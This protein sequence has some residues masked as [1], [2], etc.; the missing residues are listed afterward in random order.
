MRVAASVL[1]LLFAFSAAAAKLA[2]C[3][4]EPSVAGVAAP[5]HNDSREVYLGDAVDIWVCHLAPFLNDVSKQD[6]KVTLYIDG[7]DSGVTPTGVDR[8]TGRIRF[9]LER[10]DDN[11]ELWRD[12]L[13]NP[14][15]NRL[16]TI[17]IGVG[18][19]GERQLTRAEGANTQVT[20]NK[21]WLHWSTSL[22]LIGLALMIGVFLLYARNSDMLRSGPK[23]GGIRQAYSLARTQMAWWF[24]LVVIGYVFIWLVAGDRDSIPASLLGLMGISAATAL[25]ARAVAVPG[26][27]RAAALRKE[28]DLQRT[29]LEE[30]IARI[31]T[32]LA[33]TTDATLQATL[34][35][36][37]EDLVK[38]RDKVIAEASTVTTIFPSAGFWNDLVTDDRG[39]VALDRFQIV[40]WSLVLGAVFF[41]T[42]LWELTMPE[43]DATMLALMGISSGTYV[44]FK[45]PQKSEAA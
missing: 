21:L 34:A 42:A 40:A 43:F 20:L 41:A 17:R 31:D 28:L 6:Q 7:I 45:L 37:R 25:A 26:E 14:L 16:Q 33:A 13:Y 4:K 22:M 38:A 18:I 23:A 15:G 29:S 12:R 8:D 39:G 9:N 19:A 5:G 10:T 27:T 3:G 35:K 36:S 2:P 44:G 11:K 32:D 30:S 1:L 24:V